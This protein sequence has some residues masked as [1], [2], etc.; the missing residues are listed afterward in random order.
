M[1]EK[2]LLRYSDRIKNS[3]Q[4]ANR[5]GASEHCSHT[6]LP[7]P[8]PVVTVEIFPILPDDNLKQVDSTVNN[9]RK[10]SE[11][12]QGKGKIIPAFHKAE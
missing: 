2:R 3:N 9:N 11:K 10:Y 8:I 12:R 5:K 6:E 7:F 1:K 4:H